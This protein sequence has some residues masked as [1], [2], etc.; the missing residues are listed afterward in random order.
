[1]STSA[2]HLLHDHALQVS[3]G[4]S[5]SY[6]CPA[7]CDPFQIDELDIPIDPFQI[8]VLLEDEGL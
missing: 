1:M 4:G 3:P 2:C 8:D 7:A 5:G 6:H